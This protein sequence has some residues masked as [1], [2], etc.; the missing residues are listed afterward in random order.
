MKL[1]PL[2]GTIAAGLTIL[3][4]L[5]GGLF[6]VFQVGATATEALKIA[7]EA[8]ITA[9]AKADA[10]DIQELRQ[11]IRDLRHDL[12]ERDLIAKQR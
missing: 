1:G 9:A 6:W 8:K 12:E 7:N 2:L 3:G 4:I 10:D 11:A 5:L